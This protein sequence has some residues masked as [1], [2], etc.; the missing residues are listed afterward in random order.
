MFEFLKRMAAAVTATPPP[1]RAKPASPPVTRQEVASGGASPHLPR[2]METITAAL[3]ADEKGE[4]QEA[5]DLYTAALEQLLQ[6]L[7]TEK[8]QTTKRCVRRPVAHGGWFLARR[9]H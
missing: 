2:A 5:L 7:R 1:A 3:A 4:W 9:A 6:A 8:D